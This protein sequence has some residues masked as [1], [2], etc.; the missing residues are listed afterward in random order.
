M[1][2]FKKMMRNASVTRVSYRFSHNDVVVR[3][4]NLAFGYVHDKLI[5]DDVDFSVRKG[6]KVTIMGQNG[7]G[8]S[9]IIKLISNILKPTGGIIST[10]LGLGISMAQQVLARSDGIL[11][12][13]DFFKK[14]LQGNESGIESRI[15]KALLQVNINVPLQREVNS[16]S[17]GQQARLLL[18]AALIQDP[19]VSIVAYEY[20]HS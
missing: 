17:G 20:I 3:A 16:F 2:V 9:T 14:Q 10:S 5:L 13:H 19:D 7:S 1:F 15:S 4:N 11:T 18:A 8:K 6:S 12:V